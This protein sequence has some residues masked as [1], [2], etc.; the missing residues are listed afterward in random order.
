MHRSDFD[1]LSLGGLSE[2][3]ASARLAQQG[4]NGFPKPK[5]AQGG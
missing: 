2:E 5:S 1:A 4:P 3:E